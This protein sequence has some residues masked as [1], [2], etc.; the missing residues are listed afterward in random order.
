MRSMVEGAAAGAMIA[1]RRIRYSAIEKAHTENLSGQKVCPSDSLTNCDAPLS[2]LVRAP[3][4]STA[5]GGPPPPLR[6]ATRWRSH[7]CF[8]P[9]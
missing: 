5:V 6:F 7:T 1:N 4:P 9:S 2:K 3:A 8:D